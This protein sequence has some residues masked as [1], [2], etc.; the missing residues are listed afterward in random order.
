MAIIKDIA[1]KESQRWSS[2]AVNELHLYQEGTFLRAY[3]WSAWLACRFLH[4]FKV[5]KRQFK[6]VDAPLAYIG[7]PE[8]SLAKWLPE[9]AEQRAV[10]EK[11]LVLSLPVQMLGEPAD[12]LA[13]AYS[14]WL[15]SI[16]LAESRPAGKGS[17]PAGHAAQD[18]EAPSLTSIMQRIL[19]WPLESRSPMESMT[20]LADVKQRLA[21]LI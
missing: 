3:G 6:D 8:G 12:S 17:A 21:Q 11:H 4:D 1:E 2:G 9:G 20:F 5:N 16:P 19:A 10:G 15:D 13:A 7:F 18:P 14:E